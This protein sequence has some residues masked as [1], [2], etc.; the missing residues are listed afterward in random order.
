MNYAHDPVARLAPGMNAET[1]LPLF[2][3]LAL[4]ACSNLPSDPDNIIACIGT[5]HA[6]GTYVTSECEVIDGK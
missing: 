1:A 4:T 5:K 2:I 3:V 6:D